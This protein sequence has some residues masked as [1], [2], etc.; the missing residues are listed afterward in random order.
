MELQ[1]IIE[2]YQPQ[3]SAIESV[4]H[5]RVALLV[6]ITGVGKGTIKNALLED[7]RFYDFISYTTRAP[8][9]NN[10]IMEQNGREYNFIDLEQARKMLDEG[11]FI[12][13]KAYAG[14]VYGTAFAGLERAASS[15]Q[16]ALNDIEVQ[17]VDEYK[18]YLP[19]VISIFIVPPDFSSWMSRLKNRYQPNE[20]ETVWP[21]RR[22]AAIRELE[23]ALAVPYY[24]FVINDTVERAVKVTKAIALSDDTYNRQDDEARLIARDLLDEIKL[25]D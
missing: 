1:E 24:H 9:T 13:A 21:G 15:D 20:F 7:D 11:E 19:N 6:G 14:N 23:H 3:P 17:G 25:S 8:R 22:Q 4:K 5:S 10:G 12:E 18:R 2:N 16:V